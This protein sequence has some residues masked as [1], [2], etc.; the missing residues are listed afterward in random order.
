MSRWQRKT[1]VE[2]DFADE[3]SRNTTL[4]LVFSV[5]GGTPI[6]RSRGRCLQAARDRARTVYPNRNRTGLIR[7][8][9]HGLEIVTKP[10]AHL[11]LTR[12]L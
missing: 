5:V 6:E 2:V 4:T 9:L 8:K 1:G 3:T 11:V 12:G 10:I 7:N